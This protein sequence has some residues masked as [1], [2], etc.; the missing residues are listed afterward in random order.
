MTGI[1]LALFISNRQGVEFHE[2]NLVPY[3][4]VYLM[5]VKCSRAAVSS[6]LCFSGALCTKEFAHLSSPNT[7]INCHSYDAIVISVIDEICFKIFVLRIMSHLVAV[8]PQHP[9]EI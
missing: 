9:I 3:F 7:T 8:N 2:N 5:S 1:D 4:L 6:T